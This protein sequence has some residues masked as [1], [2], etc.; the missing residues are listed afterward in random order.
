[1]TGARA[2]A[3]AAL[4]FVL[5][6]TVGAAAPAGAQRVAIDRGVRAAG[7]WCFPRVD[8]ERSWVHLPAAAR[9]STDADGRPQFSFVRYVVNEPTDAGDDGGATIRSARGGGVLHFLVEL[10]TPPEAVAAAQVELRRQFEDEEIVLTGPLVFEGGSYA[11]VS[12][13]LRDPAAGAER[14]VLASGRAP[15]LEGNRIAFSFELAPERTELLMA[16]LAGATPDVSLVFD[17]T[18]RGLTDAYDAELTVDWAE[19]RRNETFAAGGSI[20]FVGADVEAAIDELRRDHAIRLVTRGSDSH[21]EGLLDTVYAKLLELLFR[22]VEPEAIPEAARGG[23]ADALGALTGPRGPLSSRST[24]GF[25]AYV[26]YQLKDLRSSGTSRLTFDHRADVERH[27]FVTF[28]IGDLHRRHGE[29]PLHFRTVNLDD[30]AFRQREIRVGVDGELQGEFDRLVNN[31]TVT[32]RK[33]HAGGETTVRELVLD[34]DRLQASAGDLRMVYGWKNDSD[35]VAW[36]RYETR[37]RWSFVGGGSWETPWTESDAAMVELYAPYRRRV[38]RLAGDPERLRARG[39]RAVV[40]EIEHPFVAGSRRQQLTVR[41]DEAIEEREIEITLPRDR[42]DYDYLITWQ[43]AGGERLTARG[44][45]SGDLLFVDELP[46][47]PAPDP[48]VAD[49]DPDSGGTP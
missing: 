32:L 23:L 1:V 26:G 16:S 8:E 46:P 29:D 19:V 45:E 43:L 48:P 3:P 25:G 20:Y 12:S 42:F 27:S 31:V 13:I 22:P 24:T 44:T 34:R 9:L 41:P 28:N 35:R 21:L 6:L 37:T 4:P 39:V 36:L 15:V 49:S 2:L 30:P 11:L 7:L 17:M 47:S 14:Q 33:P 40:V 5:A 18:F 10:A 38:V